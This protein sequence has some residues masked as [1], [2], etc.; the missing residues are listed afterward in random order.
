MIVGPRSANSSQ[1]ADKEK[2]YGSGVGILG[3]L[4]GLRH[5]KV[6]YCQYRNSCFSYTEG[7]TAANAPALPSMRFLFFWFTRIEMWRYM[8]CSAAS[9]PHPPMVRYCLDQHYPYQGCSCDRAEYGQ[10]S[11]GTGCQK[12]SEWVSQLVH[13]LILSGLSCNSCFSYI[14]WRYSY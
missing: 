8:G 14:E 6:R 3:L 2:L 7:D 11:K 4:R 5:K 10:C 13:G 9:M 1:I 12:I